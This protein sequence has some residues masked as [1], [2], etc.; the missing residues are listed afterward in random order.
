MIERRDRDG[1]PFFYAVD[2]DKAGLQ[3]QAI[4]RMKGKIT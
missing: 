1:F 3:A 2:H 4:D